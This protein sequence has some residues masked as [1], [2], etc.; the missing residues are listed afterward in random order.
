MWA[1]GENV[2][3]SA[4]VISPTFRNDAIFFLR[5][6]FYE[7]RKNPTDSEG[8]WNI[9]TEIP[10]RTTWKVF[11]SFFPS[12]FYGRYKPTRRRLIRALK[13]GQR[14]FALACNFPSDWITMRQRYLNRFH[15]NITAAPSKGQP[16]DWRI[17]EFSYLKPINCS[18]EFDCMLFVRSSSHHSGND[19]WK[20]GKPSESNQKKRKLMKAYLRNGNVSIVTRWL[21][22]DVDTKLPLGVGWVGRKRGRGRRWTL[23]FVRPSK[24]R[25][26]ESKVE[27]MEMTS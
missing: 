14:V 12:L 4:V 8:G 13:S 18:V 2:F 23:K 27:W 6:F 11:L 22:D 25:E 3:S 24:K 7:S 5:S 17:S 16:A 15:F 26:E 9:T 21:V 1:A 20:F 19:D 10:L